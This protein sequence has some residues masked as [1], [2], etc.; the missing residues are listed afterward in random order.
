MSSSES[1]SLTNILYALA[2]VA[3][4]AVISLLA[5]VSNLIYKR[6]KKRWMSDNETKRQEKQLSKDIVV[7]IAD[8]QPFAISYIV[9]PQQRE[10]FKNTG[11]NRFSPNMPSF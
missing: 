7:S 4:V 9:W 11:K 10:N 8:V 6:Q 5:V 3:G 1:S 2:G